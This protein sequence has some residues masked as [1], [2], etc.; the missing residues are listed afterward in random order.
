MSEI[1]RIGGHLP[2][3]SERPMF[4]CPVDTYPAILARTIAKMSI[5]AEQAK[6]THVR[7]VTDL[8]L[9]GFPALR[10][11][12]EARLELLT[13]DES[14]VYQVGC[15]VCFRTTDWRFP[16]GRVVVD[17][18]VICV[19]GAFALVL[20]DEDPGELGDLSA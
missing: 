6:V 9:E 13:R 17:C 7:T 11:A 8:V 15:D 2:L 12:N 10:E 16:E 4:V 14:G 19:T 20:A 3:P 1:T 5:Q 18:R